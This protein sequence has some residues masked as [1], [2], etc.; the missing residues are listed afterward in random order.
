VVHWP[1]GGPVVLYISCRNRTFPATGPSLAK[2]TNHGPWT[3]VRSWR[4]VGRPGRTC[5]RPASLG[6]TDSRYAGSR[7]VSHWAIAAENDCRSGGFL[8][9]ALAYAA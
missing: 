8:Y 4:D 9:F 7:R 6:S 3:R 5:G 2:A 1:L